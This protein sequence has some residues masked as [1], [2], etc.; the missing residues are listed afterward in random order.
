MKMFYF[1][2]KKHSCEIRIQSYT[3]SVFGTAVG[4]P[5]T[6]VYLDP[7]F[8]GFFKSTLNLHRKGRICCQTPIQT[9]HK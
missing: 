5:Q 6:H 3:I 9:L 1:Y 8:F 7:T 2:L 4:F